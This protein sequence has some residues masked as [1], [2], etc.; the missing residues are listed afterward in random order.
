LYFYGVSSAGDIDLLIETRRKTLNQPGELLAIEI[1][2]S[3]KWKPEWAKNIQSFSAVS[4]AKVKRKIGVYLGNET[5]RFDDFEVLP[6]DS[7]FK[8]LFQGEIF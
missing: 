5:L 4:K 1:K 7:F 3:K 6:A 2:L 8:S